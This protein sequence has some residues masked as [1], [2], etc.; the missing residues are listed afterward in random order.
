MD[1][2][3]DTS[4]EETPIDSM[5]FEEALAALEDVVRRLEAGQVP[6]EQSIDLYE[7]G[8]R[9]RERCDDRLKQ[10]ELRVEKIV[11]S[12]GSASGT[13]PFEAS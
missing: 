9:L 6:L 11:G 13:A 12:D 4:A 2:P 5:S 7:R 3:P 10:A 1:T 8:E